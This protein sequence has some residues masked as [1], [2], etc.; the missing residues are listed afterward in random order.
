MFKFGETFHHREDEAPKE[1]KEELTEESINKEL[2][3]IES[4]DDAKERQERVEKLEK[5]VKNKIKKHLKV[6]KALTLSL[7]V[8]AGAYL[9]DRFSTKGPE[10]VD[11][12]E[13]VA[14]TQEQ[15]VKE[16][17]QEVAEKIVE[18]TKKTIEEEGPRI[19][20][21]KSEQEL[22]NETL[23]DLNQRADSIKAII[24]K[25]YEDGGDWTKEIL[26]YKEEI[27]QLKKDLEQMK[28]DYQLVPGFLERDD[29]AGTGEKINNLDFSLSIGQ[30]FAAIDS[31][32]G[33]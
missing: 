2:K 26:K 16:K 19:T 20:E 3:D 12:T 11:E 24:H 33:K 29:V 30:T 18:E 13:Q 22:L 17:A 8:L 4:I 14:P 7:M 6:V 28:L 1:E 10:K 23:A 9:A 15:I 31:L 27:Q 21:E 32:E 5:E 25:I